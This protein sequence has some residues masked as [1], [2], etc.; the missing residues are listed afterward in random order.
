VFNHDVYD[1]FQFKNQT[2][3]SIKGQLGWVQDWNKHILPYLT[4]GAS[5]ANVGLTYQNEGGDYYSTTTTKP[6]WLI[7]VGVE[8]AFTKHWSL[9]SEYS[10]VDYGKAVN[11]EIPTVYGLNDPN[12]NAKVNLKS[13]NIMVAINYWI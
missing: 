11:L 6:G 7:G 5:F 9:R 8:W 3:T 4:A 2:Q 1:Q 12:G 10:F 13:N